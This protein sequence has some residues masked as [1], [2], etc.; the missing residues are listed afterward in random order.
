MFYASCR[1]FESTIN[2]STLLT[3]GFNDWK[4][5]V[6]KLNEHENSTPHKTSTVALIDRGKTAGY[7]L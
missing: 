7:A 6:R 5:A 3:I 4:I 2:A 1:L